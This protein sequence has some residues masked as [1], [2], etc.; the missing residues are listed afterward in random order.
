METQ[1]EAK[2]LPCA[3]HFPRLDPA[4]RSHS[5]RR[6]HSRQSSERAHLPTWPRQG[7]LQ[8]PLLSNAHQSTMVGKTQLRATGSVTMRATPSATP[9]A[10]RAPAKP[11]HVSCQRVGYIRT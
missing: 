3:F 1:G 6:L 11:T 7:S 9:Q 5:S 2:S 8:P 10:L 4:A